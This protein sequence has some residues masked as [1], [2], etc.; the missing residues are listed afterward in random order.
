VCSSDLKLI[1]YHIINSSQP[2]QIVY[3][4]FSGSGST[5][6]ACEVSGRHA[7]CV[8]LEP[9]FVDVTIRR[10]QE[11]TGLEAERS[12]GVK[13]NDLE[14]TV[15]QAGQDQADANLAEL[16]NLPEA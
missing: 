11:L 10:W 9:K 4:G 7:R 16:F 1:E 12:D 13:W 14:A 3:D 6:M 2:G 5:L 8:E 15:S